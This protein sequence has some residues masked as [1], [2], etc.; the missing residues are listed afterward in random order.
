MISVL[1]AG[2]LSALG[3]EDDG[4]G[5]TAQ[6]HL[7]TRPPDKGGYGGGW[8]GSVRKSSTLQLSWPEHDHG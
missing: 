5:P 6:E 3:R 4:E 8:L 2:V 7:L 1:M